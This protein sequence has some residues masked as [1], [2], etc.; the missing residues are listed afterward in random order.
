[1][2]RSNAQ[3][4]VRARAIVREAKNRPCTDCGVRYPHYVMQFDHLPEHTKLFGINGGYKSRG[5][6]AIM[7]EIAKCELVCANCHAERTY[8]RSTCPS[9]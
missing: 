4:V 8:R 2:V 5:L 6:G 1:V 7:A 9:G 3:R